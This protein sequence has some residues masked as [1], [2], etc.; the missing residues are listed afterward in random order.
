MHDGAAVCV[1][2]K[3]PARDAQD[4]ALAVLAGAALALAVLAVP[5]DE[6]ALVAEVHQGGHVAVGLKDDVP[7]AAAVAAVRPAGRNVFFAVE[8]HRPVPALT[9]AD[10]YGYL[11]NKG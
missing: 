1:A 11:V 6:F 10:F 5:G 3:R 9:G 8:G 2:Q 4:D 7:A